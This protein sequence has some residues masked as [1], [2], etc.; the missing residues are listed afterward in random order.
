M[1]NKLYAG[2]PGVPPQELL[3]LY[4]TRFFIHAGYDDYYKFDFVRGTASDQM[5]SLIVSLS[6]MTFTGRRK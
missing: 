6:G 1:E 2:G 3:P 5:D 4:A